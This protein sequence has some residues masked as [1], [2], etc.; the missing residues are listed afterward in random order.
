MN[1]G[2]AQYI[3]LISRQIKTGT[4][5]WLS[6]F[7]SGFSIHQLPALIQIPR[8]AHADDLLRKRGEGFQFVAHAKMKKIN[9]YKDAS[10]KTGASLLLLVETFQP[11][12]DVAKKPCEQF[13]VRYL[14]TLT[15]S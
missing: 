13:T 8:P 4:V 9:L 2:D 3:M 7:Y 15:L 14:P 5:S 11:I 1:I 12:M 6:L 10:V